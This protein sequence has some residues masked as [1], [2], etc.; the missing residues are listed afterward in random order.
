MFGPKKIEII[1]HFL[2]DHIGSIAYLNEMR[3]SDIRHSSFF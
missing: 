3:S 1:L 2:C